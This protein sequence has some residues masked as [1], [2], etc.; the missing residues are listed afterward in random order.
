MPAAGAGA[1]YVRGQ[2]VWRDESGDCYYAFRKT[3]EYFEGRVGPDYT[4]SER[5]QRSSR[6]G[7][8]GIEYNSGSND[9]RG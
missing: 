8:T 2:I 7:V 4:T 6:V 1:V 9:K 5:L 3:E